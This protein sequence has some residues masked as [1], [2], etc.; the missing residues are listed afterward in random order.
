MGCCPVRWEWPAH[1][2]M[3]LLLKPQATEGLALP[4]GH[5]TTGPDMLCVPISAS[6]ESL[7]APPHMV[8]DEVV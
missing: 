7:C 3:G 2:A 4:D 6:G 8:T 1:A 5:L